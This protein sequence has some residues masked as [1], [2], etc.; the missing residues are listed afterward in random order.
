MEEH[1]PDV[2]LLCET[3][4][5]DTHKVYYKNYNCV[6][7][8]RVGQ[9]LAGGTAIFLRK[10]IAFTTINLTGPFEAVEHS[11]I[12]I[13]LRN[14]KKLYFGAIYGK[15][16]WNKNF[17]P[18]L[19]NICE[20]LKLDDANNYFVLE[21]DF[22]ARHSSW[23]NAVNNDRGSALFKWLSENDFNYKI[24]LYNSKYP[25]FPSKG[26]YL[27]LAL[28]DTRIQVT[29]L[30]DGELRTLSC[31]SDHDALFF[32]IALIE[33]ELVP[34]NCN[35]I[36][37]NFSKADWEAFQTELNTNWSTHIPFTRNLT[38]T[39][40][41]DYLRALSEHISQAIESSVPKI[42]DR[43]STDIYINDKI[44]KLRQDSNEILT[45]IHRL[46][47]Q[48]HPNVMEM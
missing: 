37:Y 6:F 2:V 34:D 43:D 1:S 11:I 45:K 25:T 22:N 47:K 9:D 38:L 21:G 18:E 17:L 42:K 13:N 29:D 36:R 15:R 27:D 10:G 5:N 16:G 33:E 44:K 40:I 46:N 8:N 20:S 14:R 35:D 31:E 41:D 19:Q 4:L 48:P 7:H 30:I 32:S 24:Q 3:K 39:E 28:L 12:R 23:H 26:T